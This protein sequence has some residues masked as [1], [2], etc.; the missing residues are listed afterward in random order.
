[1]KL[2]IVAT[3]YPPGPGGIGTH[4]FELSKHL[5][6]LGWTLTVVASQD[7]ATSENV[8]AFNETLP[9]QV[10]TLP[11]VPNKVR[12][13]W[14]RYR[15]VNKCWAEIRPDIVLATGDSAVYLTAGLAQRYHTPWVA[16]EHGRS[17]LTWERWL[18]RWAFSS[19]TAVVAVSEY[20]QQR[21]KQL[22][23]RARR[24]YVIPNGAD[25]DTFFLLPTVESIAIR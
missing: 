11:R 14:E 8:M 16:V 2:L 9:F 12:Q 3:E 7:Y 22:G 25:P 18:K 23:I 6:Q 15:L 20:S 13:I 24:W 10:Y 17:P 5:A 19:A 21:L 4:A 1:M